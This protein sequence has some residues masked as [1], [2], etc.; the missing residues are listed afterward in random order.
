[1]SLLLA[2]LLAQDVQVEAQTRLWWTSPKFRVRDGESWL[3]PSSVF[4]RELDAEGP[5]FGPGGALRLLL[6][7]ERLSLE[8]WALR[9]EGEGTLDEP[10][11][12]GGAVVPAGTPSDADVLFSRTALDWRHRFDLGLGEEGG[13]R[14]Y[15]HPGLAVEYLVFDADLGFGRT[16]LDG[17]FPTPQISLGFRPLD[18][19]EFAA[20]IG[21]FYLPF[22]NGDVDILDPVQYRLSAEFRR[23]RWAVGLGYELYHLH[24]EERADEPEEDVVHLRLRSL[25]LSL[26]F[27]F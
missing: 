11:N 9:A 16:R 3:A 24:L 10:K 19:L 12:F 21:G 25:F 22:V 17:V 4:S 23:G 6:G 20:G 7:E 26:S 2:A 5:R 14:L 1:M 8:I 18:G 13:P 27:R 15:L